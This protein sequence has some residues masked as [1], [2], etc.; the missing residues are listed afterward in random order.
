MEIKYNKD[1]LKRACNIV[2]KVLGVEYRTR[3]INNIQEGE[4]RLVDIVCRFL[5]NNKADNEVIKKVTR[6]ESEKT[7][8]EFQIKKLLRANLELTNKV[9]TYKH[10]TSRMTIDHG[11]MFKKIL[12]WFK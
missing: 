4:E 12:G 8:L 7:I 5:I 2:K 11:G 9:E 10:I 1:D 3:D 6:L